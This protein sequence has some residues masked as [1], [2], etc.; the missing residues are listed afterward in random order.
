MNKK[1]LLLI[2]ICIFLTVIAWVIADIYHA[3]TTEKIKSGVEMPP[4]RQYKVNAEIL[5][6]LK[7]RP[8]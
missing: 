5:N 6:T 3:A 1:E 8:N 2:S 4:L 7:T